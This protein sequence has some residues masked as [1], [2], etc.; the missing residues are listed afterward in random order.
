MVVRDLKVKD[1][2]GQEREYKLFFH[3]SEA[4]I[5]EYEFGEV[6]GGIAEF[7]T[8]I[9]RAQDAP[10][11]IAA[12]RKLI[13]KAYGVPSADGELFQ[14]SEEISRQFTYTPAYSEFIMRLYTNDKYAQKF[15]RELIPQETIQ[16][17]LDRVEANKA[18]N[19]SNGTVVSME[20]HNPAQTVQAPVTEQ[21]GPITP[22]T[23]TM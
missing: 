3:M 17:I 16:K 1:F 5:M 22:G 21:S 11:L 12:I 4:E 19:E 18:A 2:K 10:S 6:K 8:R 14:K 7:Y 15:L 9:L 23:P 13:L 20:Q